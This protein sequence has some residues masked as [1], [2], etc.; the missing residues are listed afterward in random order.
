M[1]RGAL[2]MRRLRALLVLLALGASGG[3]VIGTWPQPEGDQ[4]EP[5]GGMGQGNDNENNNGGASTA[6]EACDGVDDD[7]DGTIDEGCFCARGSAQDRAC[8]GVLADECATGVQR[9]GDDGRWTECRELV[10]TA[11]PAGTSEITLTVFPA[12]IIAGGA[13][14]VVVEA[15]VNPVCADI[16]PPRVSIVV[17]VGSPSVELR[18][19]AVDDGMREDAVAGD[20]VYTATVKNLLGPAVTEQTLTVDGTVILEREEVRA[21]ATILLRGA[22]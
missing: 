21:S 14:E 13:E 12:E 6:G 8:V 3:C 9:C 10:S 2:F 18:A 4:L 7:G 17:R 20:G 15:T 1:I 11:V 16:T 19:A 22:P 5:G